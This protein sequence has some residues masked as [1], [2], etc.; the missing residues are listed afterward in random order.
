MSCSNNRRTSSSISRP[1]RKMRATQAFY[2]S[3]LP[4]PSFQ[5]PASSFQLP[6]TSFQLPASSSQLP[7]PSFQLLTSS[8]GLSA[9]DRLAGGNAP[10]LARPPNDTRGS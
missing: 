7:A 6:A 10:N 4:A 9:F 3:Q 5:L 1:S 8:F 2:R